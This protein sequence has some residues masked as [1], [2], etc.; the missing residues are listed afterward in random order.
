MSIPKFPFPILVVV[1]STMIFKEKSAAQESISKLV[2]NEDPNHIHKFFGILSLIH[3]AWRFA[4]YYDGDSE[5][6]FA[7]YPAWTIPTM[8]F[9]ICLNI[10]SFVFAIPSKRIKSGWRIWPEYRIHSAIFTARSAGFVMLYSYERQ[11]QL[12]PQRWMD[13]AIVLTASAAADLASF[14]QGKNASPTIRGVQVPTMVQYLFSSVQTIGTAYLLWGHRT[15]STNMYGIFVIQFN[16]FLMT[17]QRKNLLSHTAVVTIYFAMIASAAM[18]VYSSMLTA[19]YRN[20]LLVHSA[21]MYGTLLRLGPRAVPIVSTLL[22]NNKFLLW[23]M[24][25]VAIQVLRPDPVTDAWPSGVKDR[26]LEVTA[27]VGFV[28]WVV[29]GV[30]RVQQQDVNSASKQTDE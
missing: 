14:S 25:F 11:H 20:F 15:C 19:G 26:H 16:A 28:G 1:A 13:L 24:V 18:M 5:M 2:T 17:L 7:R 10:T 3:F 4:M 12:P 9:H 6:G 8:I 22:Q 23:S 21:A 30:S 29:L 27:V